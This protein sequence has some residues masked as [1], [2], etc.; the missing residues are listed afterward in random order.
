[1]AKLIPTAERIKRARAL[2]QKAREIPVEAGGWED[3]TRTARVKDTLRQARDL[4]KF[5][6][7]NPAVPAETKKEIQDLLDEIIRAE[8]EIL[9][10]GSD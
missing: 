5:A 7:Y 4:I 10:P 2:I 6:A 8:K 9:H 1:M 3:F